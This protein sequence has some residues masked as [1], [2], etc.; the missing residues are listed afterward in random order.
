MRRVLHEY[1]ITGIKTNI[2]YL[3]RILDIPEFIEGRYNTSF[4]ESNSDELLGETITDKEKL[5]S[6]NVALVAAYVD[7][8]M[9]LDENKSNVNSDNRPISR[10]KEF[11]LQKGVL[12]I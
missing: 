10:W 11:G 7:Y 8:L 3:R 12:R 2:N 1:K 6:E 5:D 4:I 9:N